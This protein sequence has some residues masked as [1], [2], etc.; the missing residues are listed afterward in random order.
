M[1]LQDM[2]HI[3]GCSARI[4]S[5]PM[6]SPWR[7]A[8][9]LDN[10]RCSSKLACDGEPPIQDHEIEGVVVRPF[11][12]I[13]PEGWQA[14]DLAYI[15]SENQAALLAW[16]WSLPCP[17]INR[18]RSG[19]WFRPQV[20][21][22]CWYPLL[23]QCGLPV[24]ETLVTNI[25]Q[26]ARDFGLRHRMAGLRG[27]AV[28]S[29]LT[30]YA[31]Y[32]LS[33]DEDWA[34]VGAMQRYAPVCLAYPHEAPQL[35]CVVGEE[36][37]YNGE[38]THEAAAL[39]PA[40]QRFACAAGLTFLQLALAAN[41]QGVAVVSVEPYPQLEIFG[42]GARRQA[43]DAIMDILTAPDRSVVRANSAAAFGRS[44]A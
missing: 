43:L 42:E 26:E 28:Y 35:V 18:Y 5:N 41:E 16:L 21:L 33:S 4:I 2:L 22:L 20:P 9:H 19:I 36:V 34:G 10:T 24:P 29:P 11:G 27:T 3:R 1:R 31:R 40:L 14:D 13:D 44:V 38:P 6:A 17:V 25:E 39:A 30:A 15:Q 32:L 12:W 37:I 23:R 8:W 7:L